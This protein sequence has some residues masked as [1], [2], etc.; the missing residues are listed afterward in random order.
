MRKLSS[1][2]SHGIGSSKSS[3]SLLSKNHFASAE[4]ISP[5]IKSK[6]ASMGLTRVAGN[7]YLCESTKDFWKVQGNKIVKLTS[8]EVD[9]GDKI[10]AAP[11]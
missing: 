11:P 8:D 3:K 6:I 1:G 2:I 7:A 9:N 10:A 5:E 4:P